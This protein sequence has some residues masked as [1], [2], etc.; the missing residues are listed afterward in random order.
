MKVIVKD[1]MPKI[2][3][4]KKQKSSIFLRV[5]ADEV[6]ATSTPKT[7]QRTGQLRADVLK[8]VLGLTGKIIWGK[9]YAIFQEGKQYRN[10]TTAGTGPHFAEN[11]VRD[12]VKNSE[13]IAKKV[14][15]K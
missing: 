10:Y 8:Q 5:L 7:P 3:N 4:D 1:N 13:S 2:V 9:R 12:V 11:A 15:L 6:V 14:G